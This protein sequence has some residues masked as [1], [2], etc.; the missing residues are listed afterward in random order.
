MAPDAAGVPAKGRPSRRR[1]RG[2]TST[3]PRAEHGGETA[4]P[5]DEEPEGKT[6]PAAPAGLALAALLAGAAAIA[7]APIFV[8][9][10]EVGPVA[11]AFW[12]VLLALPILWAWMGI[13]GRRSGEP[14]RP[15]GPRDLLALSASGLFL[16][17]ASIM[18]QATDSDAGTQ[19]SPGSG[20]KPFL[21][22]GGFWWQDL[23]G[24][25]PHR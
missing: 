6:A 19:L 8:R 3:P 22:W 4:P 12:R 25:V 23:P 17:H 15:S 18:P 14:G 10:S 16:D 1:W 24:A 2:H 9:T 21:R 5:R 20:L 11:T 13:E 7:F